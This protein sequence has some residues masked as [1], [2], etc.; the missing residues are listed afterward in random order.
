MLKVKLVLLQL[1]V[2]METGGLVVKILVFQQVVKVK[3]AKLVKLEKHTKQ[4]SL[5]AGMLKVVQ[6]NKISTSFNQVKLLH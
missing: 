5:M 2:K 3:K 4:S 1:S 6:S